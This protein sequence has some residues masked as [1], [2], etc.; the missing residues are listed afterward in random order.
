MMRIAAAGA[1]LGLV[2]AAR[3]QVADVGVCELVGHPTKYDGQTVRVKGTVQVGFDSFLM[4]GDTCSSVLWL[5]YPA[6]TRAKSGPATV[7]DLQL[8][9]NAGAP[10]GKVRPPVQLVRDKDFDTFDTLLSQKPK[11]SGMCL[12]CVRND[13]TATLT[14]RFDGTLTPGLQ[15]DS[16]GKITGLDGFGNLNVYGARLVVTQVT[17]A[18]GKEVDYAG[19]A[20][21]SGDNAGSGGDKDYLGAAKKAADAFPKGSDGAMKIAAAAAAYGGPGEQNG[22]V[23]EFGGV[24]DVPE[25]EG[26]RAAQSYPGG[27]V[28]RARFDPDKLKGDA[29]ARAIVHDG[30]EIND[31]R[32]TTVP[33]LGQME[34]DGFQAVLLETI[35]AR[36][37]SLTLPGGYVVWDTTWTPAENS[38]KASAALT[39]YLSVHEGIQ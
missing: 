9:A 10:A 35:G 37:K 23:I 1:M 18:A 26:T 28:V 12:G 27:L 20:K 38:G 34:Q 3:A 4:L 7:L 36:Q 39:R 17:G 24:A 5:S 13:V 14:G 19:A 25:G 29:L 31:L 33:G 15:R 6:G 16:T 30:A 11:T 21:V 8:A 2:V 32:A 22:V